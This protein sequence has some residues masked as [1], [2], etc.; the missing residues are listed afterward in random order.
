M[1]GLQLNEINNLNN[2]LKKT[3]KRP[4]NVECVMNSHY[5]EEMRQRHKRPVG[6]YGDVR[7]LGNRRRGS[8]GGS[9]LITVFPLSITQTHRLLKAVGPEKKLACD[10]TLS[11]CCDYVSAFSHFHPHT[12]SDHKR[13]TYFV[14]KILSNSECVGR[15]KQNND[16]LSLNCDQKMSCLC[17]SKWCLAEKWIH[18]R[19]TSAWRGLITAQV[20]FRAPQNSD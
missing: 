9:V 18:R 10:T 14:I 12:N 13:I 8:P 6:Q 3:K 15:K 2:K 5:H 4:N 1:D 7:L 16:K 20:R 11:L 19:I 17:L